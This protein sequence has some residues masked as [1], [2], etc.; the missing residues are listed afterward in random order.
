MNVH[1]HHCVI[2]L[3]LQD[4][5][6]PA[7]HNSLSPRG[8]PVHATKNWRNR[9]AGKEPEAVSETPDRSDVMEHIR[10]VSSCGPSR[11]TSDGTLTASI[12]QGLRPSPHTLKRLKS[13]KFVKTAN[14]RKGTGNPTEVDDNICPPVTKKPKNTSGG[15]V[16]DRSSRVCSSSQTRKTQDVKQ[17]CLPRDPCSI[18]HVVLHPSTSSVNPNTLDCALNSSKQDSSAS[19]THPCQL[20][21]S[22]TSFRTPVGN[23]RSTTPTPLPPV[24]ITVSTLERNTDSSPSRTRPT[25]SLSSP[26]LCPHTETPTLPLQT[27]RTPQRTRSATSSCSSFTPLASAFG[28]SNVFT[29][30]ASTCRGQGLVTPP[31]ASLRTPS[32]H[33]QTPCL[34]T[35]RRFPG[36]AGLLPSL[37]SRSCA[38]NKSNTH[39][40][41]T[42]T[43]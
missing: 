38:S 7:P 33:H 6:L 35:R 4:H 43:R 31:T 13:F 37:V 34:P 39:A 5:L 19:C 1:C 3:F 25:S 26:T 16:T 18:H 23:P 42:K 29:T 12:T 28:A 32:S 17:T 8:T 9:P 22:P 41:N 24:S 21:P 14:I 2:A 15:D 11:E 40:I 20:L 36:P 30:T 10:L 27:F